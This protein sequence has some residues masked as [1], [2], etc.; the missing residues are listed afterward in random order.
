MLGYSSKHNCSSTLNYSNKGNQCIYKLVAE[1][2]KVGH[3][4]LAERAAVTRHAAAAKDDANWWLQVRRG[5]YCLT[6]AC[7]L[8]IANCL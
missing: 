5:M 8:Q 7:G 6:H 1:H 2:A 3:V 4:A